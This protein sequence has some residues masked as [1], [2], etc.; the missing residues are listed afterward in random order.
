MHTPTTEERLAELTERAEAARNKG[1]A[2]RTVT[3]DEMWAA[4]DAVAD[5]RGGWESISRGEYEEIVY[6]VAATLKSVGFTVP[7]D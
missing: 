3:R 5:L 7:E 2:T 4:V 1:D 6:E